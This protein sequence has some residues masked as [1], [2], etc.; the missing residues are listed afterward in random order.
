MCTVAASAAWAQAPQESCP[1]N[2]DALG[3]YR[4]AEIDTTG[5]P[6]FG[7]QYTGDHLLQQGEV[8]LT[9]DDGPYPV[10][11]KEI[12]DALARQC[13]KATFFNVGS[14]AAAY[15]EI[16][17]EVM[18]QG[19]TIGTHTWSHPNLRWLSQARAI[20]Q[21][22]MAFTFEKRLLNGGVAPF[23]RFPYLSDAKRIVDYLATR[24]VAVFSIDVDSLDYRARSP[25][26]VVRRDMGGLA[27]LGK[28]I[29]LFHDIHSVTA[30]ALPTI[31]TELKAKG[32]KV[33]HLVPKAQLETLAAYDRTTHE[34]DAATRRGQQTVDGAASPAHIAHKHNWRAKT[35]KL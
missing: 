20:A 3:V 23:F 7:D 19:H 29:I 5:G 22:E 13:T 30:K 17:K 34:A 28:G 15:P 32:Y 4:V 12:L 26:D 11:T 35:Q 33:V 21:I 27:K 8:V 9:F 16:A 6:R 25:N 2:A 1:G 18:Q 24:N 10:Y 14:M 31:L